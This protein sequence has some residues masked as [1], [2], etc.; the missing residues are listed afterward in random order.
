MLG[1]LVEDPVLALLGG[2]H[3]RQLHTGLGVA[4]VQHAPGLAPLAVDGE[5]VADHGLDTEAVQHR[6]EHGVVVETREQVVVH[7]GLVGLLAVDDA[8]VE[9]GHAQAPDAKAKMHVVAVVHLG[10]VV[11]AAGLL[12]I[13]HHVGAALVGDLDE[14]L[15]DVDV[16]IAVLAHR[17]ELHEVDRAVLLGDGVEQVERAHHVVDLG[18]DGVGP[19]DHRV[20]RTALLG[21]VHDGLGLEAL[22]ERLGEAV[23]GEI[24]HEG[25][26]GEPRDLLPAPHP[27]LET[28]RWGRGNRPPS[29]CRI[30]GGRSCPPR[31]RR[32]PGATGAAPSA[33][34]DT[35]RPPIRGS[36]RSLLLIPGPASPGWNRLPARLY[37][38]RMLPGSP[39]HLGRPWDRLQN[40]L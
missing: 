1:E 8:L 29:R 32:G 40:P 4:D 22:D 6:P 25:L 35:R 10:Q 18:V 30:H 39:I 23:V 13:G 21:E 26:D 31:R 24:A 36:A 7:G 38:P 15:F 17:P 33:N 3:E 19:V 9:I 27:V 2:V 14:A 37:P 28:G 5:G 20:R 12:G 16:G 11:E 34:P